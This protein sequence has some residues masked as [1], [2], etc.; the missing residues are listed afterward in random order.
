MKKA[1]SLI[2]CVLLA[3]CTLL[4]SCSE[5]VS[6]ETTADTTS[7]A[8]NP[9]SES[10][11]ETETEAETEEPDPFADVDY[12][13]KSFTVY[14]S[15]DT[16]DATNGDRFIRGTGEYTGE[17]IN[18]AVHERNLLVQDKLG[19]TLN[20][21]EAP[22]DMNSAA[23]QIK[24]QIQ[25]GDSEWQLAANDIRA[26][27]NI[28]S[29]GFLANIYN[30]KIL[31]LEKSY[32]YSDAM[33]DLMF[34]EG[35]MYLLVGDYFTDALASCHTLYVNE[36]MLN[37]VYNDGELINNLVFDGKWTIDEMTRIVGEMY[38]DSDGD[39]KVSA[40]DTFGYSCVGMWGSCIPTLIGLD[41]NFVERTADTV[42]FAFNNE[43]SVAALDKLHSLYYSNGTYTSHGDIPSLRTAFANAQTLIMGYSRLGDFENLREI[44]FSMGVIPY[45]KF[46]EAQANYSTSLHDTSEIGAIP[47]TIV[48]DEL[49]FVLTCLEVFS[50]ETSKS[51]M[52]TFYDDGLKVKYADGLDDAKMIDLIHD[53]ICSPF[54]V[55]YDSTLGN[56]M[57]R[58]VFLDPLA[59][60]SINF[61]SNY[62]K[63][64]KVS[65]KMLDK[66]LDSFKSNLEQ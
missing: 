5:K 2:L 43:H 14:T 13:G 44:E 37:D 53:S 36:D 61:T 26:F 65:K 33:N 17:A 27:A 48:G 49:D 11:T 64:Y 55:A 1:L 39:G 30:N 3:S 7:N 34:I 56:F 12:G 59:A 52:P 15:V 62:N 32:W 16:N 29:S 45:P 40:N 42:D 22:Y 8:A 54:A 9:T 63:F 18:D 41:I 60:D 6:D 38:T 46:D 19:I 25:S 57:L 24:L 35:G 66:T 51:V 23:T 28:S 58:S 20:F 47:S 50:R 21:V 31:D 4:T 10:E